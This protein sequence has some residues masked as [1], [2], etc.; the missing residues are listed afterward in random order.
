MSTNGHS[1]YRPIKLQDIYSLGFEEDKNNEDV[2]DTSMCIKIHK[3]KIQEHIEHNQRYFTIFGFSNSDR[4]SEYYYLWLY[5]KVEHKSNI[6]YWSFTRYGDNDA[7]MDYFLESIHLLG[8]KLKVEGERFNYDREIERR[9]L[10]KKY[11]ENLTE[12]ETIS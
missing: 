7:V 9:E 11:F 5:G 3:D 4:K 6:S 1:L 10:T 8:Y 2:D 12:S